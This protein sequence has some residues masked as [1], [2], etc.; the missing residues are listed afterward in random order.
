MILVFFCMYVCMYV[1]VHAGLYVG[2]YLCR[3][4][5]IFFPYIF[6]TF[7]HTLHMFILLWKEEVD[8]NMIVAVFYCWYTSVVFCARKEN[9]ESRVIKL[10]NIIIIIMIVISKPNGDKSKTFHS[11]LSPKWTKKGWREIK[12][13]NIYIERERDRGRG[14]TK[15]RVT[16]MTLK[17]IT[18]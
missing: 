17:V 3:F 14:L 8:K 10:K 1:W 5:Y 6:S 11:K 2:I 9:L 12:R 16:N 7:T 13:I 18:K 4:V 15:A